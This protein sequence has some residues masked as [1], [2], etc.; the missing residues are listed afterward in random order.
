VAGG[1]VL[2]RRRSS[3]GFGGKKKGKY[4][5]FVYRRGRKSRGAEATTL[6]IIR[7]DEFHSF[8][9]G[10]KREREKKGDELLSFP[11]TP[12]KLGLSYRAGGGKEKKR[13]AEGDGIA[14]LMTKEVP[15]NVEVSA[16][17]TVKGGKEH[18]YFIKRK[19]GWPIA[20]FVCFKRA[21]AN[22]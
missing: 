7:L 22:H 5:F 10:G 14:P 2:S 16:Y 9:R 1:N 8:A 12:H 11:K 13:K 21:E 6:L 3:Y 20:F 18:F 15:I 17:T 4:N 19:G